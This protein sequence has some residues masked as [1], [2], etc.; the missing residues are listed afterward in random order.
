[1][2]EI[3]LN[4]NKYAIVDNEDYPFLNRLKWKAI[5]KNR[6]W[7]VTLKKTIIGKGKV[8]VSLY[9]HEFLVDLETHDCVTFKNKN[10]LDLRKQ[11]L[12]GVTKGVSQTRRRKNRTVNNGK[13]PT[14]KY[15]GVCRRIRNGRLN[16][17][18]RVAK[19][20]KTYYCG[21]FKDQKVAAKAYNRKAKELYGEFA[22]QNKITNSLSSLV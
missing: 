1:M 18:V 8:E 16:W 15:K 17:E 19:N 11:N 22:Y 4:N 9:M 5:K 14:S 7:Y 3:K 13:K 20:G 21:F 2:R 6:D 10:T 12:F